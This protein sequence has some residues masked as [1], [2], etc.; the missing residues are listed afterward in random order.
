MTRRKPAACSREARQA[1]RSGK[2]YWEMD[3]EELAA[4][5]TEFDREGIG[6]TFAEPTPEKKARH[7]RAKR[8]RSRPQIGKGTQ[9]VSVSVEKG[10]LARADRLAK[11]LHLKRAEL[12]ARGLEAVVNAE[13]LIGP[14]QPRAKVNSRSSG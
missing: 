6:E 14:A 2:P 12:V 9:V 8:K 5:T 11:R 3:V 4:N 10:L 7:A 13:V 1:A